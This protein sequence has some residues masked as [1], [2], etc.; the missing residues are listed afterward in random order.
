MT[1]PELLV[2]FV[3]ALALGTLGCGRASASRGSASSPSLLGGSPYEIITRR[4]TSGAADAVP[5]VS[6]YEWTIARDRLAR[7][8]R[9]TA[10]RPYV[11]RIRLAIVD[12]RSGL[13]YEARGAVAVSPSRA[14]RMMLIGPGGATA[15]DVWV[16]RERFRMVVPSINLEK[17]GGQDPADARGLPIGMLRWWFLAPLE[18]RL[19]LARSTPSESA[20]ILRDDGATVTVRTDGSHF[21]ALRREAGA[22]EAIDWIGR[23]LAP[24]AGA[25]GR[26]MEGRY[27][28]RVEVLVEAVLPNEPDP[29]AFDDP[30]EKGT[31]L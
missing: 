10:G 1:R 29:E 4:P 31:A 18:G 8:R 9:T 17:R 26:Y 28:L 5:E 21:I 27:G 12:P 15:L 23:G 30:D 13:Q 11:E 16:T 24:A 2:A 20:W 14:A 6:Q 3:V 19:L 25:H 7:I 22:L